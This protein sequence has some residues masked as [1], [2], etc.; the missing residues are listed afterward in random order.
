MSTNI[1]DRME[2][3][4]LGKA[5]SQCPLIPLPPYVR[6]SYYL[7]ETS[8]VFSWGFKFLFSDLRTLT[9]TIKLILDLTN[10]Q[11]KTKI[12]RQHNKG[13]SIQEVRVAKNPK[14]S[15]KIT[16]RENTLIEIFNAIYYRIQIELK[17]RCY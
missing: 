10:C 17:F 14:H 5:T 2:Q 12:Q 4:H 8:L 16:F 6:F 9:P 13:K 1:S 15:E 11:D 7:L 3:P